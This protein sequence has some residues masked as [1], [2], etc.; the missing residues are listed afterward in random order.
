MYSWNEVMLNPE[1]FYRKMR[2][3]G[4]LGEPLTFAAINF[5]IGGILNATIGSVFR[6][7]FFRGNYEL[8]DLILS[9]VIVTALGIAAILFWGVVQLVLFK[10]V[11]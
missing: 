11:G 9:I 8:I 3:E 7:H 1:V 5:L 10:I 2:T 4:G 6:T